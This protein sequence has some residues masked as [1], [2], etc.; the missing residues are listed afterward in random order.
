[1]GAGGDAEQADR[2]EQG[3]EEGSRLFSEVKV[4]NW[5]PSGTGVTVA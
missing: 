3:R 4:L 1:M 5:S 2:Q